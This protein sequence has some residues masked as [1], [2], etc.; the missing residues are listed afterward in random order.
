VQNSVYTCVV[1]S[2]QGKERNQLLTQLLSIII[3]LHLHNNLYNLHHFN[4]CSA[5]ISTLL[6]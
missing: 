6:L 1:C 4:Q 3:K 5:F 2:Q